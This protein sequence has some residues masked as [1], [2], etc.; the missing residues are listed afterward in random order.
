MRISEFLAINASGL[1]DSDR[2]TVDWI[3]LHNGSTN[4]VDLTGWFLTDREDNLKLWEF[5][6]TTLAPDEYRVVFASGKDRRDPASPLH[7]NFNLSGAGE[8]LA[9]VEPD[10]VTVHDVFLGGIPPQFADVSYG[11][12]TTDREPRFFSPPTP[13]RA[14]ESGAVG[15]A[16]PPSLSHPG[17]TI[18]NALEVVLSSSAFGAEIRYTLDGS[19]P[20]PDS[21]L[22]ATPLRI[23]STKVLR[24]R[25]FLPG[26]LPSPIAGA[27]YARIGAN[28]R[29]FSS[30]LPILVV[31]TYSRSITEGSRNPIYLSVRRPQAASGRTG[32]LQPAEFEGRAG[33]EIRGSSSAGFEKKSYG[34]E[35]QSEAG[36]DQ[37]AALLGLPSDSDWVLYAPYTDKSLMRDV[38]AYE[39]SRRAGRYA[40]RTRFVELFINRGATDLEN[41]D[42][43]GV[44]VLV[45]KVK[46]SPDR[47]AIASLEPEDLAE[48]AITGG[49]LLKRD[50]FDAN[51]QVLST[52]RGVELGIEDPKRSQIGTSQRTWIKDWLNQMERTLYGTSWRSA[53]TGYARDLDVDSFIDHH[54][55]VE[56]CKNIDGYRLS[57]Y[58]HKDRT[59]RLIMGPLWDYNLSF[60]NA[61]YLDGWRTNGWYYPNVGDVGYRW[62]TRLFQ[63]PD[64]RQRYA[65]RWFELRSGPLADDRVLSVVD[66]F[67]AELREPQKR[68]FDRWQILGRYVWPNWYIAKT[69]DDELRW[70]KGWITHRYAWMDRQF[71]APPIS[72]LAAGPV[73]PGSLLVLQP[74]RGTL[75]FTLNGLDPRLPGG[76]LR[77][78]ATAYSQPISIQDNVRVFARSRSGTNWSAPWVATYVANPIPLAITEIMYHPPDDT[79]LEYIE[80]RNIGDTEIPLSGIRL[81]G[82]AQFQ[83]PE[84]AGSLIPG[85]HL[86]IARD[87]TA[88]SASSR[89]RAR[90]VGNFSGD[91]PND[92]GVLRLEGPL[93]EPIQDFTY[94][95]RWYRSTDGDGYSLT[96]VDPKAPEPQW[97]EASNWK[98]SLLPGGT[99]GRANVIDRGPPR[100]DVVG[101]TTEGTQLRISG[102]AGES[103]SLLISTNLG[104]SHWQKR[105]DV[106]PATSAPMQWVEPYSN[107]GSAVFYRLISP[108]LIP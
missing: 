43:Q 27:A 53:T 9:L 81:S 18:T 102:N 88:W 86:V 46:I 39:L 72:N 50:R 101:A 78:E 58:W 2:H 91:L 21:P 67:A 74:Q 107:P 63:D 28:V 93:G 20:G 96:V 26:W 11:I 19:V 54:L 34:I 35:L 29:A 5:P 99:P 71:I 42:Y 12:G 1:V 7:T 66:G 68:N 4:H 106:V 40:P 84:D 100:L 108:R 55:L 62:F 85:E 61:D 15:V 13:G 41:A 60:G 44:Y 83:F 95:D 77:P 8:F 104:S 94:S 70:M 6:A 64:F 23:D 32:L 97:N 57:T 80:I 47:V 3:E 14:N 56:S 65:D 73:S 22:Y 45:E 17:G 90:V 103:A 92:S 105:L 79:A 33:M 25:T 16:L 69:W 38:L 31:N 30:N 36:L 89:A 59:G 98:P 37:P 82:V 76:A 24:A 10:G 49:Y 48:P 52:S 87:L 75:Y 51:D